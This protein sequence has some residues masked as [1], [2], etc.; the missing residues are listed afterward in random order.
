MQHPSSSMA[1]LQVAPGKKVAIIGAGPMGLNALI[2]AKAYGA[3]KVAITDVREDNLPVAEKL[4]VDYTLLTPRNM[5]PLQIAEA[6]HKALPPYG[7]EVVIDCA[8]FDSTLQVDLHPLLAHE[9]HIGNVKPMWS[10]D[11]AAMYPGFCL[12]SWASTFRFYSLRAW[13]GMKSFSLSGLLSR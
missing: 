8:G 7:P 9:V 2:A 11:A 3:S 5:T 13:A 1:W 6:L 4:G 12:T 10:N